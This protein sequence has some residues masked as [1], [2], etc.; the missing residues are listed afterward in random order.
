MVS[1]KTSLEATATTVPTLDLRVATHFLRVSLEVAQFALPMASL[2]LLRA[3]HA[4]VKDSSVK[5]FVQKRSELLLADRTRMASSL[6][7][8]DAVFACLMAAAA[9]QV[10]IPERKQ[11]NRTL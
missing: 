3:V 7:A 1:K 6:D 8:S 9:E 5:L 4:Q 2:V 11:A 10:R